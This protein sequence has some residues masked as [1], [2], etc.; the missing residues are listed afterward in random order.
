LVRLA[1][2]SRFNP[3]EALVRAQELL[4]HHRFDA[5][6]Y[7]LDLEGLRR[8]A[9]ETWQVD[10]HGLRPVD[11]RYLRAL[12]GERRGLEA[13]TQLLPVGRD[14]IKTVIEPYLLQVELIRLSGAG[15]ELSERGRR[16]VMTPA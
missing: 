7:P 12:Q 3:R 11:L 1:H 4:T 9:S 8:M 15:R 5:S 10:E 14:E 13:L 16:L 2:M 6:M